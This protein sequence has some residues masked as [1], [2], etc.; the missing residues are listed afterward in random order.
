LQPRKC[1]APQ[2]SAAG[3]RAVRL[4]PYLTS[5]RR[6]G[7]LDAVKAGLAVPEESRP[8]QLRVR[9]RRMTRSELDYAEQLRERRDAR[10]KELELDP[11]IVAAR[12]TLFALARKDAETIALALRR[13]FD[14]A[15]NAIAASTHWRVARA[16]HCLVGDGTFTNAAAARLLW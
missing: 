10:A 3:V 4:P 5:K 6:A 9:M 15:A 1:V 2:A 8:K 14:T 16:L 7:V 11:T 12:A 13:A